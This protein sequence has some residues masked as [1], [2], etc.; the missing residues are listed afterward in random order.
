MSHNRYE[1]SHN[2]LAVI[3]F[4]GWAS[5]FLT[6]CITIYAAV[7]GDG[8]GGFAFW[9]TA[10]FSGIA[11]AALARVGRA[12]LDIAENTS[13]MAT[14]AQIPPHATVATKDHAAF[15]PRDEA[16]QRSW[17]LG[18]IDVYRGHAII[19]LPKRVF[20]NDQYF[21]SVDEAKAHLN[22]VPAKPD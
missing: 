4:L 1:S 16:S 13:Q 12:I 19:G 11:L 5:A 20:T 17:P 10:V 6:S 21:D 7:Q 15:P 22:L 8:V 14:A 9:L 2:I 3:E 18:P